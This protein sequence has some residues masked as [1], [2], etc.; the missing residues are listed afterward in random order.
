MDSSPIIDADTW[1]V[2]GAG[3]S[4]PEETAR[5]VLR[6]VQVCLEAAG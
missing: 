2:L 4:T 6:A 3:K 5:A 1:A